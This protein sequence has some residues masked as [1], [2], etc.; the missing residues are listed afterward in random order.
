MRRRVFFN[1]AVPQVSAHAAPHARPHFQRQRAR[2]PG[3][4]RNDAVGELHAVGGDAAGAG[5]VEGDVD[6]AV[7]VHDHHQPAH[8]TRTRLG[9]SR[10]RGSSSR[11]P[12]D[13]AH[14]AV[15]ETRKYPNT[16]QIHTASSRRSWRPNVNNMEPTASAVAGQRSQRLA[17]SY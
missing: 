1:G 17:Q 10:S 7:F 13:G 12:E 4:R 14:V 16:L 3:L 8:V 11:A 9:P 6:G 2:G 15:S 5:M